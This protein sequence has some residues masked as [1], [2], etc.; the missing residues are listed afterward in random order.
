MR[1]LLFLKRDL[2]LHFDFPTQIDIVLGVPSYNQS[3]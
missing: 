1:D 3:W 2:F